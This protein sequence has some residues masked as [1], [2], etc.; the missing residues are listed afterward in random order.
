VVLS[1]YIKSVLGSSLDN[2]HWFCRSFCTFNIQLAFVRSVGVLLV[3]T[4]LVKLVLSGFKKVLDDV[5]CSIV[6]SQKAICFFGRHCI[7]VVWHQ[8]HKYS[9]IYCTWIPTLR[10]KLS[11]IDVTFITIIWMPDNSKL[12]YHTFL[13]CDGGCLIFDVPN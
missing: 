1:G 9:A 7:V 8:W 2:L 12:C 13:W 3:P 10:V 5:S 4:I 11:Q 6:I